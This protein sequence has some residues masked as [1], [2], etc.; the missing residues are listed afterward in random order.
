MD[1]KEISM[2]YLFIGVICYIGGVM[3]ASLKNMNRQVDEI[4]KGGDHGY[5]ESGY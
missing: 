4:I 3:S 2:G 1:R 5:Q